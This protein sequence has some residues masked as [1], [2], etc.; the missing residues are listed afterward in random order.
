MSVLMWKDELVGIY[1]DLVDILNA[2][3][4]DAECNHRSLAEY[5]IERIGL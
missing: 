2:I 3:T 5:E 4:A 1:T